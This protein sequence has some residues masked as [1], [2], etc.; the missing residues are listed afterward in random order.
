MRDTDKTTEQLIAELAHLRQEVVSYQQA[1]SVIERKFNELSNIYNAS[2]MGLGFLDTDFNC[3]YINQAMAD[4]GTMCTGKTLSPPHCDILD[5]FKPMIQKVIDTQTVVSFENHDDEAT[6]CPK[7]KY[8]RVVYYP[9]LSAD[10]RVQ[11]VG[12]INQDI[13]KRKQIEQEKRLTEIRF[14][15]MADS[16]PQL[17]W[18]CLAEGPCDYLSK[19]W[20][21]YTGHD[22]ASQLGYGWL[23]QLHPDDRQRVIDEWQEKVVDGTDFEIQF[24]IRN[25]AGDY[26]QFMTR[27]VPMRNSQGKIIKWLGSNTDINEQKLV[28]EKLVQLKEQAEA[29]NLAKTQFL[30]NMSHEIRTP[31]GAITGFAQILLIKAQSL[32][33]PELFKFNLEQINLAGTNLSHIVNNILD[34]TKIE[35]GK[36]QSNPQELQTEQ[37]VK[38]V[39]SLNNGKAKKNGITLSYAVDHDVA[40]YV[41]ADNTLLTQVLMNLVDNAVKFTGAGEGIEIRL[42][43]PKSGSLLFRVTD[44]GIGIPANKIDQVFESFE[45]VD[46]SIT[47]EYGGT[48]L[49][50]TI[51]K[52]IADLLNAKI[53]LESVL[54]EGSSFYFEV[55]CLSACQP[56]D[57]VVD[58]LS[59]LSGFAKDKLVL[60]VEDDPMNREIAMQ[61]LESTGLSIAVAFDGK[62]GVNKTLAL[63]PDL[64]LMDMQMPVMDGMEAT[65]IIRNNELCKNVPIFAISADALN[66]ERNKAMAAG[67]NEYLTKPLDFDALYGLLSSYLQSDR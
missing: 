10:G 15:E 57:L 64:I 5:S 36:I 16:M 59:D 4:T 60:I 66:E 26:H 14:R 47:R 33:I 53:W 63:Q 37:L 39:Y 41:I 19:Q 2:P 46:K 52:K 44:T 24:R 25:A 23:K 28:E 7:E 56:R 27:A 20:L 29:A 62:E 32:D 54:G 35:A 30:A 61:L 31:L 45:Q 40:E 9:V 17:T 42:S 67:V 6:L 34:L 21:E 65:K 8:W 1:H 43:Q 11:G 18:T 48:G 49:G 50:L 51:C 22:E 13:T 55:P 3:R 12:I 38:S 58:S